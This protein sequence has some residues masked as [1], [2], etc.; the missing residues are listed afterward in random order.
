ME[1]GAETGRQEEVEAAVDTLTSRML[2]AEAAASDGVGARVQLS[3]P[4]A[5]YVVREFRGSVG[6]NV[7]YAESSGTASK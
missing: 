4:S 2:D 1:S 5:R 3:A 7:H 6:M